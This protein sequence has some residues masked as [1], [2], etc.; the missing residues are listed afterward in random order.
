MTENPNSSAQLPK[1]TIYTD[2]ACL[3][4]PGPGG[5]AAIIVLDNEIRELTGCEP[6]TTNNRMEMRAVIEALSSL[7]NR[8]R[9]VVF[10][11]SQY[12]KKGFTEWLSK[13]QQNNWMTSDRRPV[14]NRDLWERLIDICS[15][16]LVDWKWIK[17]H[18]GDLYN[19]RCD[20]L[21][22]KAISACL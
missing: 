21:A 5:Y 14:K 15:R 7:K 22:K 4:N 13:W 6:S 3:K 18:E 9:V 2:G 1:V 8:C 10:T 12:L 11:D 20:K 16:H 19:E 17:G